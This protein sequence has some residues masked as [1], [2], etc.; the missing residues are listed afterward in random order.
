MSVFWQTEITS[1]K[2]LKLKCNLFCSF[3]SLCGEKIQGVCFLGPYV[4]NMSFNSP[5]SFFLWFKYSHHIKRVTGFLKSSYFKQ[6]FFVFKQNS[7]THLN[8]ALILNLVYILYFI[9]P[10]SQF[11]LDCNLF[12]SYFLHFAYHIIFL[13]DTLHILQMVINLCFSNNLKNYSVATDR[14]VQ[15]YFLPCGVWFFWDHL[16]FWF[17][18]AV[19]VYVSNLYIISLL[20]Y[21]Y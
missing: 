4:L 3:V 15:N 20:P 12:L 17:H 1:L 14:K 10:A 2:T 8:F 19:C 9:F 7:Y 13:M 5:I 11:W 6:K 18:M 16:K 21:F